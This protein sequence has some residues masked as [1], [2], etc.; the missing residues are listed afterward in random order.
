LG[1]ADDACVQLGCTLPFGACVQLGCTLTFDAAHYLPRHEGKCKRL[2]GHTYQVE[3]VVQGHV[4]PNTG[5]V[6]DFSILERALLR[7]TEQLDHNCLNQVL[8]FTPTAENIA[9]WIFLQLQAGLGSVGTGGQELA[10]VSVT[11]HETSTSFARVG[12]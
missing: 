6:V 11:V 5:M 10:L 9:A 4:D 7:V 3:A 1:P 2:H 8:S 12:A